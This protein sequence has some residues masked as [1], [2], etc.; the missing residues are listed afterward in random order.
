MKNK[1]LD[2]SFLYLFELIFKYSGYKIEIKK[3]IK[4]DEC[5]NIPSYHPLLGWQNTN[6]DIF[7][8]SAP[9]CIEG[10]LSRLHDGCYSLTD[11]PCPLAEA[12]C[13]GQKYLKVATSEYGFEWS[14]S[15][16]GLLQMNK[17][18]TEQSLLTFYTSGDY[19]K[20]S[21]GGASD[22]S[23]FELEY[24]IMSKYFIEALEAAGIDL[25][26]KTIF[27]LGCGSGGILLALKNRGAKV[28]GVDLDEGAIKYG[29]QYLDD[30]HCGDAHDY[31]KNV[32]YD[33]IILS[34][35]LEHLND[36]LGFLQDL[37]KNVT[38]G[39]TKILIDVPNLMGAHSFSDYF[40][41]FLHIA[42][43]WYFTPVTLARLLRLAGF[44][45]DFLFDRGAAMA[46]ICSKST[47]DKDVI[48]DDSLISSASAINYANCLSY[49]SAY[50]DIKNLGY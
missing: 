43:I 32:S 2:K 38:A 34:N 13:N 40:N 50:R 35:L 26:G 39:K 30:L 10:F 5:N 4:K 1:M 29:K 15:A 41:K 42:H 22:A 21:M 18:F 3:R 47:N 20:I 48:N 24:T 14:L 8:Y 12:S 49:S 28:V 11:N 31:L 33:V 19:R 6:V 25:P 27:E 9:E 7:Q 17:R 23:L 45:V 44:S 37:C 16:A 36:P 46:I